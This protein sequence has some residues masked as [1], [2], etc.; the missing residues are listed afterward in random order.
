M[1]KSN[2]SKMLSPKILLRRTSDT[3]RATYDENGYYGQ[4]SLFIITSSYNLKFLLGII[5]SRFMNYIYQR[6]CPQKGKVFAEIK[7]SIIK[8]LPI[9]RIKTEGQKELEKIIIKYVDFFYI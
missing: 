3:L 4:I 2:E 1:Y 7:P 5:N 9:I 8:E 6:K